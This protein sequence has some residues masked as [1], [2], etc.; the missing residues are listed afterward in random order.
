MVN[1]E[2]ERHMLKEDLVGLVRWKE[3][4]QMFYKPDKCEVLHFERN[5]NAG[6]YLMNSGTLGSSEELVD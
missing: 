1:I 2:D 6:S 3:N 4:W 5:N